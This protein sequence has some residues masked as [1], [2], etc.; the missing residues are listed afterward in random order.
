MI[1]TT[2]TDQ[3]LQNLFDQYWDYHLREHP[4][5]ATSFGAHH[6][7]DRLPDES[8][9]AYERRRNQE[10]E[11]LRR[12]R[13]I[14][15]DDASDPNRLN[16]D[17][18]ERL[19]MNSIREKELG[20][21]FLSFNKLF[22][23]HIS[24]PQMHLRI[25]LQSEEHY[26][27]YLLRLEKIPGFVDQKIAL[28]REG[29]D[30]DILPS[31]RAVDGVE[32]QLEAHLVDSPE[33]SPFSEAFLD[34][35]EPIPEQKKTELRERAYDVIHQKIVPAMEEFLAFFTES[36]RPAARASI[37]C[38]DLPEGTE[39]YRFLVQKYTTTKLSPNQIH[40]IGMSEVEN[41]RAEM[42]RIIRED[43]E[44]NGSFEE[45]CEH[46]RTD[47]QFYF[48]SEEALLREYRDI[49]KRMDAVL[50][51]LFGNLPRTPYG[52]RAIPEESADDAPTAFYMRP[53]GDGSTPGWFL[54]NTSDLKSRPTYEMEALA[55]HEAVPGHHLQL[56][57]QTEMGGL[58]DF[59]RV[60]DFTGFIEGW[61]LYAEQLGKEVGFYEDPHDEFGR[62]SFS[63]MRACR[64]VV[65][66]GMHHKDWD[67]ERAVEFMTANSAM[68]RKNVENEVDRYIAMPGQALSYKI[69]ERKILE[70]RRRAEK[71]LGSNFSLRRFHDELL[72]EGSVPLDILEERMADWIGNQKSSNQE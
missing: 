23:F 15:R 58:V 24:L 70:L 49:C 4:I 66:T 9:E 18:F 68:T 32:E 59:R 6:H 65:D 51:A 40:D 55:L 53:S 16:Y 19:L 64:L 34:I 36:Y 28:L 1:E 54:A 25:P 44:F 50:P 43:V 3:N 35:P 41:I 47:D 13:D 42:E 30:R 21:H 29:M 11:F 26:E 7:D 31:T 56:A 67:R 45:F 27:N 71:E 37:S 22:G 17:L 20:D 69:G 5:L 60:T 2:E 48:D 62:L 39:Y 8:P 14:D 63:I 46:L 33:N 10:A 61:G 12:L 38:E 72:S 57:L 52:V